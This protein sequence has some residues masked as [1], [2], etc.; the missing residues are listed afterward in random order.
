[1]PARE[2]AYVYWEGEFVSPKEVAIDPHMQGMHYGV[3]VFEGMRSY[4]TPDGPRIFK[5]PAHIERF[6]AAAKRMGLKLQHQP[7]QL[8]DIAYELIQRN[9]LEQAYIRPLLLSGSGMSLRETATAH[10]MISCWEWGKYLGDEP[11]R[12]MVSSYTRPSTN[13]APVQ[14]KV[15][16]NYVTHA[17]AT[18]EARSAGFHDA[19]MLDEMGFIA[20]CTSANLFVERNEVLYT[21]PEGSILP[22]ITRSTVI[23]LANILEIE[24]RETFLKPE[25]LFKADS[26]FLCGT[27]MEVTGVKQI[28]N[29]TFDMP[30]EYSIGYGISRMYN[31]LVRQS[32]SYL[33]TLI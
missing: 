23:E 32:H 4:L 10:L 30:W 33:H 8:L 12:L 31:H 7:K 27:A 20:Q 1:M 5:G 9:R 14:Y 13:T 26:A 28:D 3:G 17:L 21:P 6:L 15:C 24:V 29:H 22:G 18:H 2:P 11:V 16:G 25:E 19:L